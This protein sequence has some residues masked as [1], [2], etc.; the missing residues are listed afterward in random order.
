METAAAQ[1]LNSG[2]NTAE[3]IARLKMMIAK[4]AERLVTLRNETP[5]CWAE[6]LHD[7]EWLSVQKT[8]LEIAIVKEQER[9]AILIS[10]HAELVTRIQP[11]D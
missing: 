11:E 8:A 9:W 6:Q 2:E 1:Q 3:M 5:F 4:Q 10:R 7:A